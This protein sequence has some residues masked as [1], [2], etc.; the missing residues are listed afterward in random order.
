MMDGKRFDEVTRSLARG[1]TR[2]GVVGVAISGIV[3][4]LR[5]RDDTAAARPPRPTRRRPVRPCRPGQCGPGDACQHGECVSCWPTKIPCNNVC[6]DPLTDPLNCGDCGIVCAEGEICGSGFCG[7]PCTDNL[8]CPD[9]LEFNCELGVCDGDACHIVP[10][11]C[12]RDQPEQ[13]C[14][15]TAD[16]LFCVDW[17][18]DPR[19][20]GRCSNDCGSAGC[21]DGVCCD[22]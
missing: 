9:N 6:V 14:C 11:D 20:C 10:L 2:R 12:F 7:S 18:T 22:E 21:C 15:K 4:V 3:G 16:D 1:T 8:D 13:D 17:R 5:Q 19:H